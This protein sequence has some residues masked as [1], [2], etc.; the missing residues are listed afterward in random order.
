MPKVGKPKA[1]GPDTGPVEPDTC[2]S[3]FDD[4]ARKPANKGQREQAKGYA[5]D[6]DNQL[7]GH[8]Q[9]GWEARRAMVLR[10]IS[11]LGDALRI[12][13]YSPSAT[14]QMAVA[15]ALVGK[16]KCAVSMLT[17]LNDLGGFPDL[18]PEIMKLKQKEK[19]DTS[20]DAMRKEADAA[21][22]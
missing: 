21:L 20:F 8:E 12:D 4:T 1:K 2:K 10:A 22:P 19:Q 11:T 13:P 9:A 5:Q 7:S 16:K 6:A 14:Y 15:Y 3:N 18:V 17:R